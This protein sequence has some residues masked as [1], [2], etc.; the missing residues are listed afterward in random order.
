MEGQGGCLCT[1][2]A[3]VLPLG[4][5]G[6]HARHGHDMAVILPGHGWREFPHEMEMGQNIN[7]EDSFR[8]CSRL[9]YY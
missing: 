7:V 2:I 9:V 6:C 4:N 1:R 8:L 5:E 3:H